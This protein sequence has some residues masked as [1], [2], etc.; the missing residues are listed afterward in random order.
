MLE[1]FRYL[2]NLTLKRI[3]KEKI[4]EKRGE[5]QEIHSRD[6]TKREI[7]TFST[8]LKTLTDCIVACTNINA[9]SKNTN[10]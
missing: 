9:K 5:N 7:G 3:L 2:N 8:I 10:P 6:T 4:S 1:F